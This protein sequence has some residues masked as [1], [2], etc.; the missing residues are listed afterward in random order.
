MLMLVVLVLM[1]LIL[2]LGTCL[3]WIGVIHLLM[4]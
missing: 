1:V 4:W 3:S 2:K